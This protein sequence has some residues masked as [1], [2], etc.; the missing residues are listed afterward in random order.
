[1]FIRSP[2]LLEVL[3]AYGTVHL[4]TLCFFYQNGY[5][6]LDYMTGYIGGGV[7]YTF[8]EYWF[9]RVILHRIIFK[10]AH[11]HHH[12]NPVKLKII[13]TP[14][15]PVQLYEFCLMLFLSSFN[16]KLA[17]V[18][19]LG[20]SISQIIMDYLH[21]F[22]HSKYN[23]WFLNCARH[24]HKHHHNKLNWD[25]GHG[26]TTRF[27]D[28][29]F[30][31]YPDET[32]TTLVWSVHARYPFTKYITIPLP[33][34]DFLLIHPFVPKDDINSNDFTMPTMQDCKISN[35][36]IATLSGIIVGLSPFVY[37]FLSKCVNT[38]F[39]AIFA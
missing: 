35:L 10:T 20:I 26:L 23:P 21:L 11:I 8:I 13:A 14:L 30:R 39:N 29:V 2:H 12:N 32:N 37:Y 5:S 16:T 7:I 15:L 24:W 31:T 1:M 6:S 18:C 3:F 25:L 22:I 34:I 4:I 9:H 36:I 28:V 38:E 19:Q 33:L 17:V 27:W